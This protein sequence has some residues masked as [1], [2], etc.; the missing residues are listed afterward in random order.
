MNIFALGPE[1]TYSHEAAEALRRM[2]G[3]EDAGIA[4]LDWNGDVYDAARSGRG[5]AVLPVENSVGGLVQEI[6]ARRLADFRAGDGLRTVAEVGIPI[7]HHLLA[8]PDFSDPVRKVISHPQALAQCRDALDSLGI[9]ERETARS[10]AHAAALVA[11]DERYR[12]YLAIASAHAA[13]AYG[14]RVYMRN[15]HGDHM[16]LTRFH[17]VRTPAVSGTPSPTGKDKMIMMVEMR[18][19]PGALHALTGVFSKLSINLS[20]IHSLPLGD[21][22]GHYAFYIEAEC[23]EDDAKGRKVRE[24]VRNIAEK[25]IFLGSFPRNV[26]WG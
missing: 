16:L 7:E 22:A 11:K 12:G 1:G 13:R 24:R 14:L 19:R 2:V 21:C 23:H 9:R 3:M 10:T 4:L 20:M 8:R 25:A 5:Y 26:Q 15:A 18:N 17:L 6:A